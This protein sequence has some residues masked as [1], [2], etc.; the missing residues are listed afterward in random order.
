MS[1]PTVDDPGA[2]AVPARE[3][4]RRLRRSVKNGP[5]MVAVVILALFVLVAILAPVISPHSPVLGLL[6]NRLLPPIGMEGFNPEH[7]LGTD[8]QG[9]DI[10]SRLIY[11]ARVSLTVSFVCILLTGFVGVTLGLI[12]GYVG[13]LIDS[14]IM[15]FADM[16]LALPAI[17]IAVLLGV[18]YGPSFRNVVIVVVLMLWPNYARVVRGETLGLRERGFVALAKVAG[19]P[20]LKLV[21]RHIF[22]NVLPS[23]SVLATLHVGSVIMLE[24]SLSFLGVGI[25]PPESSWGTMVSD[26]RGLI[27]RAWWISVLPGLLIVAVVLSGNLLGDWLRDRLDPKLRTN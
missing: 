15:R 8:R 3:L 12:S 13:G 26:G 20:P 11:G 23:V 9:R 21:V 19:V 16:S 5:P 4:R 18:V 1:V 7:L 2:I 24:A 6:G 14:L 27:E 17:L 25:P 10:L 22:P